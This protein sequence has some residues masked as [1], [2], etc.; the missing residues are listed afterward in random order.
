MTQAEFNTKVFE[1]LEKIVE[2][3]HPTARRDEPKHGIVGD[4][5]GNRMWELFL[6]T[7]HGVKP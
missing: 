6:A 7:Y 1:M 5:V 2:T 3:T 4:E